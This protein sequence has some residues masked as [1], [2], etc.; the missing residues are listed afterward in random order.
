MSGFL[1]LFSF[2]E[3]Q[4]INRAK[5]ELKRI[6]SSDELLTLARKLN[7]EEALIMRFEKDYRTYGHMFML[8]LGMKLLRQDDDNT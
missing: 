1:G 7:V 2:A 4:Y 5:E 3:E 8:E 6:E